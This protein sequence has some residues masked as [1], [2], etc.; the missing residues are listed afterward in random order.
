MEKRK[1]NHFGAA[2]IK[3]NEIIIPCFST[4]REIRVYDAEIKEDEESPEMVCVS[5]RDWEDKEM[6]CFVHKLD[7]L[8]LAQFLLKAHIE[9]ADKINRIQ[10]AAY[11]TCTKVIAEHE[12]ERE[13]SKGV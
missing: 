12:A 8:H 3:E 10:E 11:M 13:K 6:K 7:C 9:Y 1:Y 2:E 4:D 5:I